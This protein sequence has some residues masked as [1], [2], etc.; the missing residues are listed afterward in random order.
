M[1]RIFIL[2]IALGFSLQLVACETMKGLGK[3]LSKLGDKIEKKSGG[4]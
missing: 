1:K 3:H 4:D 2:I